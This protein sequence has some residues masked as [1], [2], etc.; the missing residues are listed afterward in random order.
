MIILI[1]FKA[2]KMVSYFLL[3]MNSDKFALFFERSNSLGVRLDFIDILVAKLNSGFRLRQ[4]IDELQNICDFNVEREVLV[5]SISYIVSN[6]KN[7]DSKI[8]FNQKNR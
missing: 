6:H 5:R 4:K 3:D 2:E 1:S 8:L 7:I